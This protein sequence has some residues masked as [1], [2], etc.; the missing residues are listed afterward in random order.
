MEHNTTKELK[1]K[2]KTK[3]SYEKNNLNTRINNIMF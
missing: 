1:T 2:L 3:K